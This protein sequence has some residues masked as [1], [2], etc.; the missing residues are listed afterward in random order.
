MDFVGRIL[1]GFFHEEGGD[2]IFV[3]VEGLRRGVAEVGDFHSFRSA[4]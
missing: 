2:V 4:G 1:L 3:L